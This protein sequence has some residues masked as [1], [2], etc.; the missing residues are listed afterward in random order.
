MSIRNDGG[1]NK[2]D[3][4]ID[5]EQAG[6]LVFCRRPRGVKLALVRDKTGRWTIP[7]GRI[8]SGETPESCAVR[9]VKE[10]LGLEVDLHELLDTYSFSHDHPER[11]SI[12]KRVACYLAG[13][14]F[15][16]LPRVPD[17]EGLVAARWYRISEAIDLL[18]YSEVR[19]A[20]K[21]AKSII[22]GI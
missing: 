7:K 14:S 13:T 3:S 6:A 5:E 9:E 19:D 10:E 4:S 17:P 22:E 12:T 2:G 18:L 21:K 8:E 1:Q 16:R 15:Q 20:I 11:G